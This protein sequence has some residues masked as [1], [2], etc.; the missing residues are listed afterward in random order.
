VR[1][2]FSA[3]QAN[4]NVIYSQ[5]LA[6]GIIYD[7][8][9]NYLNFNNRNNVGRGGLEIYPFLDLNANNQRDPGEPK[10]KG[11]ELKIN[12][13]RV[14]SNVRDTTIQVFDLIPYTSYL[15]E[16]NPNSFD[17]IAWQ[18]K[19]SMFKVT[20]DPNKV[21]LLEIPVKVSGEASGMVYGCSR[22]SI[23]QDRIVIDF[24]QG[25]RLVGKTITE[26]DGNFSFLGLL[27]G[28][29]TACVDPEQ[30]NKLKMRAFPSS[31][32]FKVKVKT[33]GDVMSNINFK[34]ERLMDK[35]ATRQ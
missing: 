21:K 19:K 31:A 32:I 6:G 23:G 2:S 17:N 27:P 15:I 33:D 5:T 7:G 22:D 10:I 13:G 11:L 4:N 24:Y 18:L 28:T 34:L 30:L 20:I 25:S 16:L 9:T 1:A 26:S 8:K 12:G 35:S 3:R 29:Y 14:Q